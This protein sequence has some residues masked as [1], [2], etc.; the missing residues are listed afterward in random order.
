[1]EIT[2]NDY[3]IVSDGINITLQ[4]KKTKGDQSNNPGEIFFKDIGYYPNI[5]QACD[6]LLEEKIS[7]SDARDISALRHDIKKYH[8]EIFVAVMNIEY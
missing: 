7:E 6:R 2:I 1:M 5:S 3:R 4:I 8:N